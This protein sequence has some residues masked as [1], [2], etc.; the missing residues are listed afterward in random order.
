MSVGIPKAR[1]T[2]EVIGAVSGTIATACGAGVVLSA[3][4][5]GDPELRKK[6]AMAAMVALVVNIVMK[7]LD[8]MQ[9][10]E[11]CE[12]SGRECVVATSQMISKSIVD[13]V[14]AAAACYS[15]TPS[16]GNALMSSVQK[17]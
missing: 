17:V 15:F 14:P 12:V 13:I 9:V 6:L 3:V 2:T 11:R 4:T 8:E 16:C 7:N 5:G 1:S 10:V